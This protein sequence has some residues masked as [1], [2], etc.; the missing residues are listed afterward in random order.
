ML[1]SPIALTSSG[2]GSFSHGIERVPKKALMTNANCVLGSASLTAEAGL[3]GLKELR[4]EMEA[5]RV[6][7]SRSGND[8][9]R[10]SQHDD[11]VMAFALGV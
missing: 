2:T 8:S 5:Y 4:E 1:I 6:R 10:S 11:F 7:T 9:F 3:A